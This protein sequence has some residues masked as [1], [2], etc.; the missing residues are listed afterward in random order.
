MKSISLAMIAVLLGGITAGCSA[1][2]SQ[3]AEK[4]TETTASDKVAEKP[5]RIEVLKPGAG[6]PKHEEDALKQAI[7]KK[8]NIDLDMVMVGASDYKN[9]VNVRL[10]A[11]NYPD[12]FELDP[13]EI[14]AFADKGLLLD[15]TPYI[16]KLK[17]LI[18]FQ[19][20][21]HFKSGWITGKQ[22]AIGS[23]S[24]D[25][26]IPF[27]TFWIRKDWLD[28]LGLQ[29]PSTLDEF[30]AVARAFT[31]QD[32]DGNGKKDT[33]G[34]TG[35]EF[36]AFSPLFG[37]FGVGSPGTLYLKNG[38]LTDALF[39]PGMKEALTYLKS[40]IESGGVDM[41][42]ITNKNG[43]A[44]EKAYQGKAGIIYA[45]WQ[46]ILR[47]DNEEKWKSVNPNAEW[48]Q[49]AS[50]GGLS[51][52]SFDYGKASHLYV[53]S[54]AA[55]KDP[56]KLQKIL[57]FFNYIASPEGL[58]LVSYGI[59]GRHYKNIGGK[60]QPNELMD[61]EGGYFSL[62]QMAGRKEIEYLSIRF[63]YADK[64]LQFTKDQ[65]RIN[66]LNSNLYSYPDGFNKND[67]ERFTKDELIKF[68]FG[69]RPISEYDQFLAALKQNFKYDAYMEHAAA[70]LKEQNML[71]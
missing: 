59:D 34:L 17:T 51:D 20:E 26:N 29:P 21:D 13:G 52:A 45:G 68:I 31:E 47:K 27:N 46:S 14:K 5:V 42:F 61:K 53:I 8:L 16:P 25:G 71:K 12:V 33:F 4:H 18:D 19:G 15:L 39:D 56:V 44:M 48:I 3:S 60:I 54:K 23:I 70:L 36:G 65:R 1:G 24:R 41:E 10:A 32:P 30:K 43:L 40:L 22:L 69:K 28:K 11:G 57:D 9:K 55:E 63:P 66:E 6:L 50:P 49:L 38:K 64:A 35:F 37:S 67:L 7:D 62:Y 58:N 2:G